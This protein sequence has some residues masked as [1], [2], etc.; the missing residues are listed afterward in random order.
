[1]RCIILKSYLIGCFSKKLIKVND[2]N[3]D[4]IMIASP[5]PEFQGLDIVDIEIEIIRHLLKNF[6]SQVLGTH[7]R[8]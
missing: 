7:Q 2:S 1:M 3:S 8:Q 4:I 6:F 5:F